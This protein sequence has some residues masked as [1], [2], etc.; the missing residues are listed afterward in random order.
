MGRTD[1]GPPDYRDM[2]PPVIKKN[3]GKWKYH[4]TIRPGVLRHVSESGDEVYTVRTGSP[5]LLSVDFIRDICDVA[6][7][8]CDGYL[9]FTSRYNIEFMTDKKANVDALIEELKRLGLP[10]GGTGNAISNIVHTQ[11]WCK[12]HNGRT[13]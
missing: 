10:V 8:Y 2:L 4:E 9:R 3:Y 6:D 12:G 1:I 5:R 11:G 7:K 13:V